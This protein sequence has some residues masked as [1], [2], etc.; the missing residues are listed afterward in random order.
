M[1]L[2]NV[3]QDVA[4]AAA[5][6]EKRWELTEGKVSGDLGALWSIG[7]RAVAQAAK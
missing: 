7:R 2:Q 5:H 3:S 4:L 6:I 1:P